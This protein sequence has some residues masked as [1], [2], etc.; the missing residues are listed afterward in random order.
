MSSVEWL[1]DQLKN[2]PLPQNHDEFT[3]GD[4]ADIVNQAKEMCEKEVVNAFDEGKFEGRFNGEK[5]GE[6]YY[7]ETYKK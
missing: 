7:N 4:I 1:I 2:I 5:T 6:Q 3:N